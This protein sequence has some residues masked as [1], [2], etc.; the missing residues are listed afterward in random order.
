MDDWCFDKSGD[1]VSAGL[2]DVT[3]KS[4]IE[5]AQMHALRKAATLTGSSYTV[6]WAI[7]RDGVWTASLTTRVTVLDRGLQ[8]TSKSDIIILSL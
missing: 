4:G 6:A 2:D 7:L 5:E 8:R 3:V 1:Y